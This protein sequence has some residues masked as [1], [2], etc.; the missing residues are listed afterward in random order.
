MEFCG[1]CTMK[2]KKGW[3]YCPKCGKA[4][5]KAEVT[6]LAV[7]EAWEERYK[8]K[9]SHST[10][11]CYRAAN[12]YF[13]PLFG[14]AF[15]QIDLADLQK[16]VD[17][18]GRRKRTRE[19]MKALGGL[20]YKY[21]LPRHL[22]DMNYAIYLE[23]GENDKE[24]HPPFTAE[25]I[26]RI[27]ISVGQV[28]YA[29]EIYVLIYTGFRPTELFGL[30]RTDY[31]EIGGAACLVGGCKT[32]AGRDRVVTVS[33]RIHKI[34]EGRVRQGT[35]EWI[36]PDS[37]GNRMDVKTFRVKCF[38]PALEAMGIQPRPIPGTQAQYVPYSCRHTFSNLLKN[39]SG[40]DRDKADLMGHAEYRTTVR[41]YQSAE[42]MAKKAI[43]DKL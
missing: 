15:C 22:S 12:K 43:T 34:I 23:T 1:F 14:K 19:N 35:S 25:Q 32:K 38:Y 41:M 13:K 7:Y 29:E 42:I 40:S 6:F 21:A 37:K 8:T 31:R 18:C 5:K 30:R 36:F 2:V 4:L 26:E 16:C 33:P 27:R 10:L 9:I 28:A 3:N 24:S 17:E 39:V 20:L 11:N